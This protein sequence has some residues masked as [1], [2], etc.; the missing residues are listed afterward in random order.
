MSIASVFYLI[1]LLAGITL[2]V[3]YSRRGKLFR[4][5]LFTAVTGFIA[6]GAVWTLGKFADVSIAIT[7]FTAV[8]SGVLGVPGVIGM[9]IFHLI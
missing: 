8:V 9:L 5:L 2:M 6:L 4:M 7:P 1:L 3:M